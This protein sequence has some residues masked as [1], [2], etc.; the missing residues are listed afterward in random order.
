M[1]H[2][3]PPTPR[4]GERGGGVRHV[5]LGGGVGHWGS[6]VLEEYCVHMHIYTLGVTRIAVGK[7]KEIQKVQT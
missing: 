6:G 5:G 1:P 7:K 2:H 4:G 3:T